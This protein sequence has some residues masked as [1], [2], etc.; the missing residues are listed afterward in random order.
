MRPCTWATWSGAFGLAAPAVACLQHFFRPRSIG[1]V[2][3]CLKDPDITSA[4]WPNNT[5]RALR[6]LNSPHKVVAGPQFELLHG[7]PFTCTD[8]TGR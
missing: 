5:V 1:K 7:A 3:Y 8:D 2:Q 6:G 4:R